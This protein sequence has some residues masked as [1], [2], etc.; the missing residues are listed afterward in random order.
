MNGI[1]IEKINE[2]IIDIMK[3]CGFNEINISLVTLY[4]K[5]QK[6][7][8]RPFYSDKFEKIALYSK[9]RG[10]NVRGYFILGLPT[11]TREEIIEIKKLSETLKIKIFPSVYYNIFNKKPDEWKIQ[12]SSV[13]PNETEYLSRESLINLFN[14]FVKDLG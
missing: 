3:E 9:K 6:T 11:Q 5:T 1:S 14:L 4:E 10:L 12:R 13:F 7:C 2:D 8:N